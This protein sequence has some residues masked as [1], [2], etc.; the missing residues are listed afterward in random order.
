META[1]P[2]PAQ[3]EEREARVKQASGFADR[4]LKTLVAHTLGNTVEELFESC[5]PTSGMICITD[6]EEKDET[7]NKYVMYL[8]IVDKDY[9]LDLGKFADNPSIKNNMIFLL[10]TVKASYPPV[11][12]YMKEVAAKNG[13]TFNYILDI[14][15]N[16]TLFLDRDTKKRIGI[17]LRQVSKFPTSSDV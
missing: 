7:K 13:Y 3:M 14:G 2:T 8:D 4:A 16:T 10:N 15:L 6:V 5:T 12:D 9:M 11:K 17:M 1:E